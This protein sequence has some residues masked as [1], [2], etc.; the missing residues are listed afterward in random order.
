MNMF[1]DAQQ[2]IK[3]QMFRQRRQGDDSPAGDVKLFL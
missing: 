3:S 1:T 2:T